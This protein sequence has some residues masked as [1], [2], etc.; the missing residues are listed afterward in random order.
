MFNLIIYYFIF[1]A[2]YKKEVKKKTYCN[3]T[4]VIYCSII[5]I[6]RIMFKELA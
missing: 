3:P 4:Q 5:S 6:E 1:V 2:F